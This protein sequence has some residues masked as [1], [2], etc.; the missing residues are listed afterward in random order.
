MK[1]I[2][3]SSLLLV[4]VGVGL[5]AGIKYAAP[6]PEPAIMLLLGTGLVGVAGIIRSKKT[7]K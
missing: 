3:L 4:T 2:V 6:V 7:K 5:V 1:K